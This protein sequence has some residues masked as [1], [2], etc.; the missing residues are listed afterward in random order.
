MP[1]INDQINNYTLGGKNVIIL[2]GW[3]VSCATINYIIE[4]LHVVYKSKSK[5]IT[6]VKTPHYIKTKDNSHKLI[7]RKSWVI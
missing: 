1:Y 6:P 4:S 5:I 2:P 3:F 7:K